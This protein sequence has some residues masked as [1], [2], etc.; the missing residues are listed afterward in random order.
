MRMGSRCFEALHGT[1]CNLY[2]IQHRCALEITSVYDAV[3]E[4]EQVHQFI[5]M[6]IVSHLCHCHVQVLK[7]LA[8]RPAQLLQAI[9][10]KGRVENVRLSAGKRGQSSPVQF[11]IGFCTFNLNS[12]TRTTFL[13]QLDTLFNNQRKRKRKTRHRWLRRNVTKVAIACKCC[14]IM[15]QLLSKKRSAQL[16]A[17]GVTEDSLIALPHFFPYCTARYRARQGKPNGN[18]RRT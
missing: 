11:L 17:R 2:F 15:R 4:Y 3:H 7:T 6:I 8:D 13:T 12:D 18:R 1:L 10:R 14:C 16:S 9:R 5:V